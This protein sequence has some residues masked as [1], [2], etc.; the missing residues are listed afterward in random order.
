MALK[1]LTFYKGCP[2]ILDVCS[3]NESEQRLSQESPRRIPQHIREPV[4][5]PNYY[6]IALP[7][8]EKKLTMCQLLRTSYQ[9][10]GEM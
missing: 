2:H 7:K 6:M 4:F 1:A 8:K 10:S 5:S 9:G 3:V